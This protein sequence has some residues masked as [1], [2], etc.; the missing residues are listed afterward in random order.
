M[1]HTYFSFRFRIASDVNLIT[2]QHPIKYTV[3]NLIYLLFAA[4]EDV[5]SQ[6]M[7]IASIVL[8]GVKFEAQKE[9]SQLPLDRIMMTKRKDC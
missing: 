3:Q 1:M 6:R 9:S 2:N 8:P 4:S 5:E 7:G